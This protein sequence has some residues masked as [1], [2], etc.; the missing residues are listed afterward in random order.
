[1]LK[2]AIKIKSNESFIG[3]EVQSVGSISLYVYICICFFSNNLCK[4]ISTE[5]EDLELHS[6]LLKSLMWHGLKRTGL[7]LVLKS[8]I[9]LTGIILC[10]EVS[11]KEHNI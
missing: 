2:H 6:R 9:H 11:N 7:Y 8:F 4:P 3:F 5:T 10:Y 1:M